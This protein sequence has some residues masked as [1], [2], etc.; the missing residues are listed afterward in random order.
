[1]KK[2]RL[3]LVI[4]ID[5]LGHRIVKESGRF[6]FLQAPDGPLP[7]VCGYSSACI[8]SLLTG[9]LP[10][11]HGH[12]AMYQKNLGDSVFRNYKPIVQLISGFFGRDGFC[13]RILYRL[14]WRQ[15]L[16]GYFSLYLIPPTL[17]PKFDLVQRK[18]IYAPGAFPGLETPFDAVTR[19][20]LSH[21]V[22]HWRTPEQANREALAD[23]I[24]AGRDDFLFF[25]SPH[26]D[27]VMHSYSTKSR[28][29][30]DSLADFE[31]FTREMLELAGE[32]YEEVRLL[33]FG[34]HG[35]SD[36]HT[37]TNPLARLE[38]LDLKLDRDYLYFIDSTMARFWFYTSGAR[39][40][41]EAALTPLGGGRF[42]SDDELKGLGVFY[43]DFR[44]GELC[45]LADPG[46]Q[47]VPS[48]MGHSAPKAMHGY[49]P[50][51]VDGDTLLL[52]NYEHR[53]VSSIMDIGPL[54][55][56]EL[57]ALAGEGRE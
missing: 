8:P 28:E 51:D 19:L 45:Y 27:G 23:A 10:I 26:L 48:F 22:F 34:D 15:G 57:E 55:T 49:H 9:K 31:G 35:M 21:Q 56:E 25:Y 6:E 5:A 11:D 54:I 24:K 53:P 44:Y 13:Q 16:G 7:S 14:I 29:T 20:G 36:T 32:S 38:A 12:W 42:V 37:E 40:K 30:A 43:P 4:M 47:F 50:S 17:L 41:V 18:D 33:V 3:V 1:L 39:E 2:K 52:C 46:V